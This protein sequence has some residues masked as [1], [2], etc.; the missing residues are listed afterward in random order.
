MRTLK[1]FECF[2]TF[3]KLYKCYQ[4]AQRITKCLDVWM[5]RVYLKQNHISGETYSQHTSHTFSNFLSKV[6]TSD[7]KIIDIVTSK[8]PNKEY[9]VT[10]HMNIININIV[11]HRYYCYNVLY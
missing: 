4:I 8:Y 5:K 3:F 2:F 11:L 7:H 9:M 1:F 10:L 6:V